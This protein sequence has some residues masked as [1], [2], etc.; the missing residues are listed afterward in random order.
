LLVIEAENRVIIDA[1]PTASLIFQ[2]SREQL[3]GKVC[4]E[5][6][7][8]V[9]EV[10]EWPPVVTPEKPILNMECE[11]VVADQK[12]VPVV[13]SVQAITLRDSLIYINSFVD[14][15]DSKKVLHA[16]EE[17]E[18]KMRA[19][20]I[21]DELSGL[22]NRR[23]FMTL[24]EKQLQIYARK[25]MVA[26]L[27]YADI[28]NLKEINDSQ[29]HLAGDDMILR[30]ARVL[31]E[32]C[33]E[34]DIIGRLGGDEFAVLLTDANGEEGILKR[35]AAKV[36]EVNGEAG[37]GQ[38]L[39][40]SVGVV[41]CGEDGEGIPCSLDELLTHADAKMYALKKQRKAEDGLAAIS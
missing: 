13:M 6:I 35:M 5:M 23:G 17:S 9:G 26:Y 22:L 8:P 16:L 27:L 33:R 12:R 37:Q 21:S 24:V 34:S 1:N 2:R 31:R 32:V 15:T 29:G 41:T 39:S 25:K 19:L 11:L 38:P 4:F 10:D 36:S 14:I 18:A 28:D 3:I 20:S 7:A 40:L 30:T